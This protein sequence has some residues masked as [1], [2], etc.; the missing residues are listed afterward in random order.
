MII[1][2]WNVSAFNTCFNAKYSVE[3]KRGMII[4][5]IKSLD[6]S[7]DVLCL[8][9]ATA[10]LVQALVV[11]TNY[12][13]LDTV[14]THCEMCC[15]FVRNDLRQKLVTGENAI[16][17]TDGVV[18]CDFQLSKTQ[19][20][21]LASCHLAPFKGN[22][23]VRKE[24]LE[25]FFKLCDASKVDHVILAGDMNV[26]QG[27]SDVWL[28]KLLPELSKGKDFNDA[29]CLSGRNAFTK[30]TWDSFT[31]K[32]FN[33]GF[34]FKSRFDR[35]II[36]GGMQC[37]SYQLIGNTPVNNFFLSDHFGIVTELVLEEK[38]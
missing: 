1:L 3:Q 15:L 11:N 37:R 13:L 16:H 4:E 7:P 33:D 31:N 28:T 17:V 25:T 20:V 34:K 24:Q 32:Y 29:W 18:S 6:K 27:E 10:E 5:A 12:C 36:S 19:S 21:R 26:R 8:Q 9:E 35:V 38:D 2:T 30:F 23:Q 14:Q 22:A